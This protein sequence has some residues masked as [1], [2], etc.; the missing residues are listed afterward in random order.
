MP[1][2]V[3]IFRPAD[4]VFISLVDLPE[5]IGVASEVGVMNLDLP[6]VGVPDDLPKFRGIEVGLLQIQVDQ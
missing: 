3:W 5:H 2:E 1:D 4:Q 6:S